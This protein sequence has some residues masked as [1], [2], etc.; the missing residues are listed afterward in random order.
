MPKIG[1][2]QSREPRTDQLLRG[3]RSSERLTSY[4]RLS[5]PRLLDQ[6]AA[7]NP[8]GMNA[9]KCLRILGANQLNTRATPYRK[10]LS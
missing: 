8:G 3:E 7:Y 9:K 10:R 2:S 5:M 4:F 1:L 6:F